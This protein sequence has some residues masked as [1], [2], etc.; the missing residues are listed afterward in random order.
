M[1]EPHCRRIGETH[2][3]DGMIRIASLRNRASVAV[4]LVPTVSRSSKNRRIAFL[5]AF[6][7]F[8]IARD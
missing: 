1:P 8:P 7:M 6:D 3:D 4:P 5:T 2:R